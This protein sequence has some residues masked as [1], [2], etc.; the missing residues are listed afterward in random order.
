MMG[1]DGFG[2]MGGFGMGIGLLVMVLFLVLIVWGLSLLEAPRSP[3]GDGDATALEILR[4]R[5]ARGEI[6]QAEYEQSRQILR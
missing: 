6:S 5:Y 4:R 1:F 3:V 2:T